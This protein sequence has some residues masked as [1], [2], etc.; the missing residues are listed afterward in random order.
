MNFSELLG[1]IFIVLF[2]SFLLVAIFHG[3]IRMGP[4]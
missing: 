4:K 3:V 1:F 2:L